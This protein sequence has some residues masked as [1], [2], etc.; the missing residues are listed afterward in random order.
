[1]L[2]GVGRPHGVDGGG[3]TPKKAVIK[4]PGHINGE[5]QN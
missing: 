5:D 1:M 2:D 3:L 4:Q